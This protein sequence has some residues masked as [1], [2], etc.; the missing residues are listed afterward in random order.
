MTRKAD[1]RPYECEVTIDGRLIGRSL[2][3]SSVYPLAR[4]L[5]DEAL[6]IE[7]K[8]LGA[9]ESLTITVRRP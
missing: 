3:A 5:T 7:R 9:E 8:G 6:W 4:L 2:N 1:L